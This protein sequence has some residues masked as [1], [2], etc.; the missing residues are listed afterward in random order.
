MT[1]WQYVVD[2]FSRGFIDFDILGVHKNVSCVYDTEKSFMG[3]EFKRSIVFTKAFGVHA[4]HNKYIVIKYLIFLQQL[5]STE[6][7]LIVEAWQFRHHY[8]WILVLVHITWWKKET[9]WS[10]QIHRRR[11]NRKERNFDSHRIFSIKPKQV[12]ILQHQLKKQKKV[13]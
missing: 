2:I 6:I 3:K 5:I 8:N 11:T 7:I 9:K 10:H 12:Q 13:D 4:L 1:Q